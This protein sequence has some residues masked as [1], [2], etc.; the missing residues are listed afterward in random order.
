MFYTVLYLSHT[1]PK[2]VLRC[3]RCFSPSGTTACLA[4]VSKCT[5]WTL[6]LCL[7]TYF[8]KLHKEHKYKHEDSP[9]SRIFAKIWTECIVNLDWTLYIIKLMSSWS[10]WNLA[11][12][13]IMTTEKCRMKYAE[14][15]EIPIRLLTENSLSSPVQ[16]VFLLNVSGS[17]VLLIMTFIVWKHNGTN[18]GRGGVVRVGRLITGRLA[19]P[20]SPAG[21]GVSPA[22]C[23]GRG[24]LEQGTVPPCSPDAVIG[25]PL[26]QCMASVSMGVWPCACAQILTNFVYSCT[27]QIN[28]VLMLQ[29]CCW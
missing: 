1:R 29:P 17:K 21:R 13:R 20:L 2:D 24:A 16:L 4:C 12:F 15:I 8:S 14:K 3:A 9:A 18:G 28:L 27:W 26:L 19:F 25:C 23:H 6:I 11:I 10:A 5:L 22:P 7:K